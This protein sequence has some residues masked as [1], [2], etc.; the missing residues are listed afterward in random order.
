MKSIESFDGTKIAYNYYPGKKECLVFL[1]GLGCNHTFWNKEIDYF[2]KKKYSILFL[3]LRGHGRSDKPQKEYKID[4]FVKDLKL[5]LDKEKIKEIILVGHSLGGIIA[6]LFYK[7]LSRFVKKLILINAIHKISEGS[8]KGAY[9]FFVKH[10][11]DT[12]AFK[13]AKIFKKKKRIDT[14]FKK[15]HSNLDIIHNTKYISN[16]A[17]MDAIIDSFVGFDM[18]DYLD[19]ISVPTLILIGKKD[20]VFK[21]E[22]QEKMCKK[23]KDCQCILLNVGHTLPLKRADLVSKEIF[24]F[25][26]QE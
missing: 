11:L 12:I 14:K 21:P 22:V 3:D 20:E 13:I 8:V 6:L 7:K 19:K 18:T 24:K 2:K 17:V 5:I 16:D 15:E 10:N 26:N 25:L 4:Y 23:I 9:A 1:H